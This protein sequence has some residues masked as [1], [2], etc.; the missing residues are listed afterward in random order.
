ML[1]GMLNVTK[2]GLFEQAKKKPGCCD[3]T[4]LH[5]G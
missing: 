1:S 5:P 4:S 2:Q 3:R